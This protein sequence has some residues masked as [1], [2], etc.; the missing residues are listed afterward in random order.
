MGKSTRIRRGIIILTGP[1]IEFTQGLSGTYLLFLHISENI[2]IDIRE[3]EI[4]LERGFYI[5]VGSAFGAGG[6]TSRLHRHIR[7]QKKK[8]W[9]IDQV[10][11]SKASDILGIAVS[12]NQKKECEIYQT[13]NKLNEFSPIQG[14]GN[15]DCK[16]KCESHF[17][18]LIG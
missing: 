2:T 5:Y 6:L 4:E 14:F 16:N 13:I 9:H 7:K 10:T 18:K 12:I 11:M 3:E 15:S 8:H 17:L 1:L